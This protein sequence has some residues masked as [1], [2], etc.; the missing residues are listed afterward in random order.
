MKRYYILFKGQVQGVG[1]RYTAQM[2]AKK[3]DLTGWVR[4]LDDGDVDMEVQGD[5]MEIHKMIRSL[6][7]SSRW[8]RIDNHFMKEKPL[9]DGERSFRSIYG[10]RDY[11]F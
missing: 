8:I 7:T 11:Y 1:F 3:H 10:G 9:V 4:N 6:Y 2:L 5:E